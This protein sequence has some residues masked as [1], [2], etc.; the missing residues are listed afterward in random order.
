[1]VVGVLLGHFAPA[2]PELLTGVFDI[3]VSTGSIQNWIKQLPSAA[4]EATKK[5][6]ERI[7]HLCVL[8]CDETGLRVNGS[9]HWLHCLCNENWSY[10]VLHKKRGSKAMEEMGILLD[11]AI[12]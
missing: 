6:R 11:S 3:T 5:I 8:N 9:L 10:L 4:K 2:L 1:M 12:P 7:S